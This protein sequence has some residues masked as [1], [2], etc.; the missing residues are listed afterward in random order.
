MLDEFFH[1][2][3]GSSRARNADDIAATLSSPSTSCAGHGSLLSSCGRIVC[4]AMHTHIDVYDT[5]DVSEMS[6][7]LGP[8]SCKMRFICSFPVTDIS[9]PVRISSVIFLRGGLLALAGSCVRGTG[10]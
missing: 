9:D 5:H 2:L 6:A 1:S 8:G 7:V 3:H 4:V 10:E